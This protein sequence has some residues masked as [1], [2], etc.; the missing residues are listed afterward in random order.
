MLNLERRP[1]ELARLRRLR[2][3][4]GQA[5]VI[6]A[7]MVTLLFGAV[8]IA[9]DA[10][11][12]YLFGLAAERTAAA[13]A[14][15]A[16]VFMPS[17]FNAPP[18][19]NAVDRARAIAKKNGFDTNDVANGVVVD[20]ER[21][22]IPGSSPVAYYTNKLQVTV[23]RN[24]TTT[25]MQ[26]FGFQV[27]QVSRTATATYQPPI[28]L[29]QPGGQIGS[30]TSQLG[31]GGSNY[32]FMRTEGWKTDRAQGDPFTPNPGFEFGTTLNPAS[33]D[34]H[35]ISAS[36]GSEPAD[37]SLPSRGG[38]NYLITIPPSGGRI[39][40]YNAAFS[41]DGNGGKP[42]NNC[43]NFAGWTPCSSGGSY[44][45]HE[46]DG[47]N[48]ADKTTFTAMRYTLYQVSNVFIRANDVKL[49]QIT[50]YPID[51][52]NWN[53]V[54]PTY[55]NVKSP[56]L[57]I[58]QLY[59]VNGNPLNMAAYH[60]WIDVASYQVVPTDQGVVKYAPGFQPLIGA[61]P[62]GSYRLRV[63]SLDYD[64]SLS[65]A[66]STN[67]AHK[68]YAVRVLDS[69]N[70]L[71]ASACSMAAW[72]DMCLY[73]PIA[74][75]SFK[76]PLFELPPSYAGKTVTIDVYDPGDIS[77][78]GN[79]TL[80]VIDPMTGLPANAAPRLVNIYDLGVQRTNTGT[81]ISAPGNTLASYVA[82]SAGTVIYNGHWVRIELP[83][84]A[85]W[86][87]GPDPNNWWWYLQYQTSL[88]NGSAATDTVTV[89]VGL[90]G[91]PAHLI[92]G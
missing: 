84:P 49:S 53:A 26:L 12:G 13:A 8:G 1:R 40:V 82:T 67:V 22:P 28:S 66:G 10:A 19:N 29:G 75:G 64:G 72:N 5:I 71:C 55:T 27:Y 38:Y 50:V 68:A 23:S 51:A 91:N 25:F 81:L 58:T 47:I 30:T 78:A 90:K 7:V 92:Q 74:S 9:V 17:E 57:P 21:V 83:I 33:S 54:P 46:E 45:L 34:V 11:M 62:G 60:N 70:N 43:E 31:S 14:V 86:N 65:G 32:F 16:V 80:N 89:A 3:R 59:D 77:G 79:V 20:P 24:V 15:S 4:T 87:P 52:T 35:Q 48:F 2:S 6:M 18:G 42:H 56:G 76:F 73:T 69:T 88:P 37:G 44:Y 63:D 39:Q 41:P 61:L 36:A 85:T